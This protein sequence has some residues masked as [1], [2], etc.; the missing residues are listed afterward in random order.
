MRQNLE[1]VVDGFVSFDDTASDGV[2]SDEPARRQALLEKASEIGADWILAVDP[3][4]RFEPALRERL[5]ELVGVEE[6]TIWCFRCRELFEP[7]AYRSDGIWNNKVIA[8]L[9]PVLP[10]VR[11]KANPIHGQWFPAGLK[12]PIRNSELNFYH[13]KMLDPKRRR[14]R[15][16][17]YATLDPKRDFHGLGYDYLDDEHGLEL[18]KIPADRMYAPSHEDDGGLWMANVP[19]SAGDPAEIT[20]RRALAMTKRGDW[21][22]AAALAVKAL[23]SGA[24]HK[25]C[26]LEKARVLFQFGAYLEAQSEFLKYFSQHKYQDI[27]A[28]VHVEYIEAMGYSGDEAGARS[29]IEAVRRAG[30]TAPELELAG[31]RY[32]PRPDET[33]ICNAT[34]QLEWTSSPLTIRWGTQANYHSE[35]ATIVIGLNAPDTLRD[36]VQSLLEQDEKCLIVVVSSGEGSVSAVLGALAEKVIIAQTAERVFV[37]A[38]RNIGASLTKSAFVAFLAEDCLAQKD[39]VTERLRYHKQGYRAVSSALMP[40]VTDRATSW[41][42]FLTLFPRR[43]PGL[44]NWY[45]I[46]YGASYERGMILSQNWFQHGLRIAEDS[47]FNARPIVAASMIMGDKVVTTH[48]S[49][50]RIFPALAEM[51]FRGRRGAKFTPMLFKLK[52]RAVNY[53][54]PGAVFRHL[55][56]KPFKKAGWLKKYWDGRELPQ[57]A[58][59]FKSGMD[60]V[61]MYIFFFHLGQISRLP[62]ELAA[63]RK[64]FRI[65]K[66]PGQVSAENMPELV[67]KT[68]DEGFLGE[69]QRK[70]VAKALRAYGF[71]AEAQSMVK[72]K[73]SLISYFTVTPSENE[74]DNSV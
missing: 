48:L 37:G 21:I 58:S 69:I 16:D 3:D 13:L 10:D 56:Y 67:S 18:T 11:L 23:D 17:L 34:T 4:E 59:A 46:H 2:F 47:A 66:A 72:S 22:G 60:L 63:R 38:A 43:L 44:A 9:F 61:F 19:V 73:Q 12:Y 50:T 25:A 35:L 53:K 40:S 28:D 74:P 36:A 52:L 54:I 27:P 14:A 62:T 31:L 51:F 71:E 7:D 57:D 49:Q 41:A 32:L 24:N 26:P 6:P 65:V 29:Q 30:V 33:L 68:L 55:F 1:S 45:K 20:L 5:P 8:R 39:W 42:Q 70:Q 64:A 15:R